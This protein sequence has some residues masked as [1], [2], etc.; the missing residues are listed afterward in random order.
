MIAAG[1]NGLLY[2]VK[3]GVAESKLKAEPNGIG[4]A[5]IGRL[6]KVG[7]RQGLLVTLNEEG[8]VA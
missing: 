4:K 3:D 6:D 1:D 5:L 8:K 7:E 2:V